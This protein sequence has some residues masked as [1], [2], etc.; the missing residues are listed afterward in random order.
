MEYITIPDLQTDPNI[1]VRYIAIDEA[2]ADELY[3]NGVH[4]K[5]A[6]IEDFYNHPVVKRYYL[7]KYIKEL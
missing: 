4:R 3:H 6:S 1:W 5:F 2:L 7:L